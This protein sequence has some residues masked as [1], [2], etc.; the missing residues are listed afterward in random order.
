MVTFFNDNTGCDIIDFILFGKSSKI[1]I[2]FKINSV[3]LQKISENQIPFFKL[4]KKMFIIK[5]KS[6]SLYAIEY[7]TFEILTKN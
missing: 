6:I 4:L 3:L 7:N 1:T 2:V 5:P